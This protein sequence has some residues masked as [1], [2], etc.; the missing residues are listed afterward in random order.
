MSVKRSLKLDTVKKDNPPDEMHLKTKQK[1]LNSYSPTT[2]TRQMSP[3]SSP[4]TH[5]AQNLR[6]HPSNGDE[7]EESDSESRLSRRGQPQT[8][9]DAFLE[10]QSKVKSS[11]ARILNIRAK[12]T[13]LQALEGSRELENIGVSDL[14]CVL[15]AEV[16]RTQVLMSQAEELQLLKRNPGKLPARDKSI[17][18]DISLKHLPTL[19]Q[20]RGDRLLL[21]VA[22]GCTCVCQCIFS[23]SEACTGRGQTSHSDQIT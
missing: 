6:N 17:L 3:F 8:E 18:F 20:F 22:L 2:G 21:C 23:C 4:T 7:I 14:P 13:S 11:L 19:L 5:N 15:S 1:N 16:Q 12:L 9:E 10:L